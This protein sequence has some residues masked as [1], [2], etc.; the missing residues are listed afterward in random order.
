ME[1]QP[2]NPFTLLFQILFL[3]LQIL[4]QILQNLQ[5]APPTFM[6]PPG[7]SGANYNPSQP[8]VPQRPAITQENIEEIEFPNG[9][10]P[11][12]FMPRKIRIKRKTET[13]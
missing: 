9:F 8:S 2:F 13:R 11:E 6:L 1:N 4:G 10:D 5:A 7:N 12:T 3:P